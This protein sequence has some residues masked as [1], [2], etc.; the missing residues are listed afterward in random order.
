MPRG[1]KLKLEKTCMVNFH[2]LQ[3][4]GDD[5]KEVAT[6]LLLLSSVA[7]KGHYTTLSPLDPTTG[8]QFLK[9]FKKLM[10]VTFLSSLDWVH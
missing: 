10:Q 6:K 2:S 1:L 9:G 8:P 7:S 5:A 4:I 3:V